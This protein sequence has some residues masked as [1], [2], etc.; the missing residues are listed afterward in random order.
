MSPLA[1]LLLSV[2]ASD[3]PASVSFVI[4]GVLVFK[5]DRAT[6]VTGVASYA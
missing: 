5:E 3:V 6:K 1:N 4:S 2:Y